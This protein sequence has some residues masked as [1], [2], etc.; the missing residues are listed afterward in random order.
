MKAAYFRPDG[1]GGYLFFV[2]IPN[3]AS[4]DLL[5]DANEIAVGEDTNSGIWLKPRPKTPLLASSP[6]ICPIGICRS[7]LELNRCLRLLLCLITARL[8][9]MPITLTWSLLQYQVIAG[10]RSVQMAL[11]S[12]WNIHSTHVLRIY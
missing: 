10:C 2:S 7:Q 9:S 3:N 4:C 8:F 11:S 1:A 5:S 6:T 12:T